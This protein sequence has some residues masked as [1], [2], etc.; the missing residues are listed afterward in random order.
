MTLVTALR[1]Y[2]V[3]SMGGEALERVE[4]DARGLV[5][6]R[7]WAVRDGDSRL[8]S[9]K[10]TKRM[11]RRDGVFAFRAATTAEGVVVSG[12]GGRQA[13]AG[14]P[15]LDAWL[16]E[17]LA[18]DATLAP[19]TDVKHFDDSPV[20]LVGTATLAWCARE[21]GADADPRRLRANVVVDTTEPFEEE[22]WVDDVRIGG[23]VLRPIGRIERCRTIDLPQDGVAEKTRWL[24]PL[25]RQRDM[26]VAIYLD[27][28]TPGV[29]AV[30]DAVAVGAPASH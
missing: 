16:S 13:L 14:D 20:S 29:I 4:L 11:V 10:N 1:R 2:P 24:Q 25:G 18:A 28:V 27:V 19:E 7:G 23:A 30:G 12:P 22:S 5:G 17:A 15:E 3:K 6:D 26:R 9:G 8:A 21:L